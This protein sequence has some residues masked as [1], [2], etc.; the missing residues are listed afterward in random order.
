MSKIH[1]RR[2]SRSLCLQVLYANNFSDNKVAKIKK[3]YRVIYRSGYNTIQ[4]LEILDDTL[5][6]E[7]E[8]II[9]IK[10]IKN[11]KRGII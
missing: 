8:I 2:L 3:A 6:G 1:K 10:F 7:E 5:K 9:I 4:A 11:S